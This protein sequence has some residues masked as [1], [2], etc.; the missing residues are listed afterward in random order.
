MASRVSASSSAH[1]HW[2]APPV[3]VCAS[4]TSPRA[5]SNWCRLG[6]RLPGNIASRIRAPDPR[7]DR[8]CGSHHRYADLFRSRYRAS[9]LPPKPSALDS[10][11]V[12]SRHADGGG[13]DH[14]YRFC[15]R[16]AA[17]SIHTEVFQ[18]S[19]ASRSDLSWRDVFLL[20]PT[21]R[22]VARAQT[23]EESCEILH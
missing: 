6:H 9:L 21:Q 13:R 3:A 14:L 11:K 1:G 8:S 16:S 23:F 17:P 12:P 4:R 7:W 22:Q 19:P 10:R 18:E 5:S 15:R 20:L 2:I